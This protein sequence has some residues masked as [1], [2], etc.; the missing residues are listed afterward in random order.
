MDK[1]FSTKGRI[2]RKTYTISFII[3]MAIAMIVGMFGVSLLPNTMGE[4]GELKTTAMLML[5]L[6]PFIYISHCLTVQRLHDLDRP[7]SDIW[8][9]NLSWTLQ[10]RLFL[11]E[12]TYG[13]NQY[14][15]PQSPPTRKRISSNR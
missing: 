6:S 13:K 14:G 8:K 1:L 15:Y 9:M 2:N 7:G 3:F 10:Y 11:E 4:M 12:G 5:C